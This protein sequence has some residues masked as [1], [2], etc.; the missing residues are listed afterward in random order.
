LISIRR[1]ELARVIVV[2]VVTA[3]CVDDSKDELPLPL[4]I[5]SLDPVV[6]STTSRIESMTSWGCSLWISW[7]RFVLVTCFA[8]GPSWASFS[9]ACFVR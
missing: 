8:L 4:A 2:T 3:K 5:P 1:L 6:A 9:W 7:P